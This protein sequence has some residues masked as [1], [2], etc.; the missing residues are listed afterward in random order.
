MWRV[1]AGSARRC[2][3]LPYGIQQPA[4][5]SQIRQLEDELGVK[6]FVRQPFQLTLGGAKLMAFAGPFFDH[7]DVV[8]ASL[9][10]AESTLVRVAASEIV[11]RDHMPSVI[12]RVKQKHAGL[13]LVLRDPPPAQVETLLRNREL[14]LAVSTGMRPRSGSGL[15]ARRL[16]RVPL[17]L[18][19][20]RKSRLRSAAELW[21][22]RRIE[23]PL[24][25]SVPAP[26]DVFQEGLKRRRVVWTA[27]IEATSLDLVTWYVAHEHG[28]GVSIALPQLIAHRDVRALPLDGF[29]PV[30][31][32]AIWR[33]DPNPVLRTVL[34]EARNYVRQNWP[35]FAADES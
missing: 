34:D 18:L 21:A 23:E 1:M 25:S 31:I 27:A 13:R 4:L 24:V 14:D 20:H 16:M 2:G 33:G 9:A 26:N 28:I 19:V 30:E 35:Q 29:P 8:G 11:L 22:R 32:L 3:T 10:D 15:Q 5:S 7:I 12:R 6:L 17:V